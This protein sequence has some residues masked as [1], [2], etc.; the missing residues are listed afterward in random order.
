MAKIKVTKISKN[1]NT[2]RTPLDEVDGMPHEPVVGFGLLLT[3]ST[4]ESGGIFTSNVTNVDKHDWGYTVHTKNS[5]YKIEV[6]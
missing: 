1:D 6:I 3:S 4:F 5:E 2:F